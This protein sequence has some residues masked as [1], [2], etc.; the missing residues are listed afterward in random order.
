MSYILYQSVFPLYSTFPASTCLCMFCFF[1]PLATKVCFLYVLNIYLQ[2]FSITF[3]RYSTLFL[4]DEYLPRNHCFPRQNSM[5]QSLFSYITLVLFWI[6][7]N[8]AVKSFSFMHLILIIIYV[9]RLQSQSN[10]E[11]QVKVLTEKC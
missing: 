6:Q 1:P 11:I 5:S 10:S 8:I 3:L 7:K 2:I 9:S 4:L